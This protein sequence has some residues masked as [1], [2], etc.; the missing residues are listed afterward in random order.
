MAQPPSF[1]AALPV[2]LEPLLLPSA[3]GL[4][5]LLL[6]TYVCIDMGQRARRHSAAE[7]LP[8]AVAAVLALST[9]LWAAA[10]LGVAER[11]AG[12]EAGFDLHAAAAAALAAFGL[13]LPGLHWA[14]AAPSARVH[15]LLGAALLGA[16]ALSAQML[17]LSA[18]AQPQGVPWHAGWLLLA[19]MLAS[20]GFAAGLR[21][22]RGAAEGEAAWGHRAAAVALVVAGTL[23]AQLLILST[24]TLPAPATPIPPN[25]IGS[26]TMVMLAS[27]GGIELLL[28]ML[29]ACV[30]ELRMRQRLDKARVELEAHALRDELTGLPNRLSSRAAWPRRS[31]RP[32]RG[33]TRWRCWWWRWMASS[34]STR[35]SATSAATACCSASRSVCAA[36]SHRIRPRGW[37]A[38]SS[39]CCC[40]A[41]RPHSRPWPWRCRSSTP[42]RSPA[43]WTIA[44]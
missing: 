40:R 10:V 9:G 6:G 8:W 43:A 18:V 16:A 1:A 35:T 25:A 20:S 39:C 28:L 33:R 38:T 37:A 29:L 13:G 24:A 14:L 26:T 23:A 31:T 41:M 12:L 17:T 32:T 15:R 36:W 22:A 44:N 3:M 11:L 21:L 7:R 19:W 5:V 30:V 2:S 34:M 27:I 42:C 4:L